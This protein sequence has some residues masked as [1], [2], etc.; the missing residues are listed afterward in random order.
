MPRH[1]ASTAINW[2]PS[3]IEFLETI[4]MANS[5]GP[6]PVIETVQRIRNTRIPVTQISPSPS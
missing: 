4:F 6:K 3:A 5:G 1:A 2:N